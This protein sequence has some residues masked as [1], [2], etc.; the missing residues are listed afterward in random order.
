MEIKRVMVV[1]FFSLLVG[2]FSVG[3]A[4]AQVSCSDASQTI[5]RISSPNNAHGEVYNGLGSYI[6]ELCFDT[7]FGGPYGGASPHICTGSNLV[8]K[9]S[10]VTNAHAQTPEQTG[11]STDVCYGNL[12]CVSR[13]GGCQGSEE[14]IVTLSDV[15]NAHLASG[16]RYGTSICCTA[17]LSVD[18]YW[19]DMQDNQL[20]AGSNLYVGNTVKLV[21]ENMVPGADVTFEIIDEDGVIG[22]DPIRQGTP[23]LVVT[24]D[25][26]GR[27]EYVWSITQADYATGAGPIDDPNNE[28]LDLFFNADD[29]TNNKR[30]PLAGELNFHN[31]IVNLPPVVEIDSSKLLH[32]GIYF[33]DAPSP[34]LEFN[35]SMAY[36]PDGNI[37]S[38]E[39]RIEEDDIT[40]TESS[41][42][43]AFS[44]TGTKTITVKITDN[45]G[46]STED[47]IGILLMEFEDT[48]EGERLFIFIN[49]PK[50]QEFVRDSGLDV[51]FSA[52]ESF[53]VDFSP[54]CSIICRSGNC[55][56]QTENGP[57]ACG[58]IA[59][60]PIPL[61]FSSFE[62]NWEFYSDFGQSFGLA[63]MVPDN[64][65]G[66]QHFG[67]QSSAL[68]DKSI[69]LNIYKST[70]D[71]SGNTE[72]FF[73]L[74][75]GNVGENVCVGNELWV[76]NGHTLER[77]I[78]VD[79]HTGSPPAC[80][81]PDAIAGNAD[82][83]TC[84]SSGF[85]CTDL[86]CQPKVSGDPIRCSDYAP[87]SFGET[88]CNED[89]FKVARSGG[90]ELWDE[91]ECDYDGPDGYRECSCAWDTTDAECEL[92]A[93]FFEYGS[94]GA[95][96]LC[97]HVCNYDS[98]ETGACN[99]G[100]VTLSVTTDFQSTCSVFGQ[101]ETDCNTDAADYQLPCGRPEIALG[102][103]SMWQFVISGFMLVI[104]YFV[105]G[106][107]RHI[108]KE[109]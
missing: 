95:G 76:F 91:L 107:Y 24:A 35:T 57:N 3:G 17:G 106:V 28:P 72:R 52:N 43:H 62:F 39:W 63:Y 38:W 2:F 27:A 61:S 31:E 8:L 51:D 5:L 32:R 26:A 56:A 14:E 30:G 75:R 73:T 85:Y 99:Q 109:N 78:N 105:I 60:P 18:A 19:A 41:F 48:S 4:S 101:E 66:V 97:S 16:N 70:Y 98:T 1:V 68:N 45:Q 33:L 81:G 46:K 90:D 77:R 86:G 22:D 21:A 7:L 25:G 82:D 36:D 80:A 71:L 54:S 50:H 89:P 88:E 59:I 53:I 29:G 40:M 58:S 84:A 49:K 12:A 93:E 103:F 100:Y 64:P 23:D 102:F 83:C 79:T 74:L 94:G 15:T 87:P 20:P 96:P 34:S 108:F 9:L 37:V 67:S 104:V 10:D 92:K 6:E 47:Q 13:A 55:P 69:L 65:G 11:Y 42:M 44:T